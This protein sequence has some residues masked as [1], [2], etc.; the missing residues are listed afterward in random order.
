MIELIFFNE[1]LPIDDA[2]KS[3]FSA[4]GIQNN[5]LEGDSAH[6]LSGIY[7]S[8][9]IF[10]LKIKLELNS[11]DYDDKYNYMISVRED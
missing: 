2:A 8:Y 6:V 4:I 3:I 10:G 11:Y 7:Y 5:I 9:S 1:A